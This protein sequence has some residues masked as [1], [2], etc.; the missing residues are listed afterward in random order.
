MTVKQNH[1][2][3]TLAKYC[4]AEDAIGLLRRYRPYLEAIPSLRR[5]NDSLIP[6]PFPLIRMRDPIAQAGLNNMVVGA[7]ETICLPCELGIIMCEPDWKIKMGIEIFVLIYRPHE[8]LSDLLLRWRK[9]QVLLSKGYEWVM[10]FRYRHIYSEA[11]ER[12]FPLFVLFE[13]TPKR[14]RQGL[15]G[16]ALP[17][18]VESLEAQEV[19]ETT[20]DEELFSTEER[21][22]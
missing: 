17:Y 16:A 3:E 5:P 9:I 4:N 22:L 2:E 18:I 6:I 20:F 10:P 11:A 15:D 8:E 14:I 7:N 1:Y 12:I 19:S 13:E 21:S